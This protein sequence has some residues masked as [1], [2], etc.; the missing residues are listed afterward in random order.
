MPVSPRPR[1]EPGPEELERLRRLAT[2]RRAVDAELRA[3][4]IAASAAGGS[5]RVIAQAGN[6]ST[7]TVYHWLKE[8]RDSTP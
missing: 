4:V 2:R 6:L 1:R 7:S 8:H 5:V 3:A